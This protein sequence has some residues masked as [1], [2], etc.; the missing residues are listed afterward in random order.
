MFICVP[1][2]GRSEQEGSQ[3]GVQCL[4]LL[5][6]LPLHHGYDKVAN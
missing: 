1:D 6:S 3:V 5:L 2:H 4:M